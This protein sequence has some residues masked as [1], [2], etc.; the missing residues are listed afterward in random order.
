MTKEQQAALRA[1]S[2]STGRSIADLVRDGIDR[3][4]AGRNLPSREERIARALRAAGRFGSG[5]KDVSSHHDHHLA[6]VY[7]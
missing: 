3:L 1:A 2:A 5:I 7:R 6:E 4:I